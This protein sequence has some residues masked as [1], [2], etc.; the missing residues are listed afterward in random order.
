MRYEC[1]KAKSLLSKPIVADSWFH[2][3]RSLNAYRGCEHGCVYCDGMSEG[4]HVDD[5]FTCVRAK[6]NAPEVLRRELKKD[7][8]VAQSESGSETL[9]SF[10][11]QDDAA[12]LAKQG[13]RKQVIGVCGGVSDGYQPAEKQYE[14]TRKNLEVLRDFGMPV[15]V[16]TKSDLVLRDLDILK[17]IHKQAFANVTFTITMWDDET[18]SVLEPNSAS[19]SERFEALKEVRKAGLFGGVMAVPLIPGIGDTYENITSLA[20]E[21]KQS[22]A[23]SIVFGGLT[24][25]PGRQKEY[26]LNAVKKHFPDQYDLLTRIYSKN[27]KY[28]RPDHTQKPVSVMIRGHRVCE[29]VGISDRSVRHRMPG[30]FDSN[31]RV[32]GVLLD[33]VFYQ[34]YALGRPWNKSRRYHELATTLEQGVGELTRLR[35]EGVLEERLHVDAE[36]ASAVEDILDRGTC[37]DL[38]EIERMLSST[39]AGGSQVFTAW[40]K[41]N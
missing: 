33:I 21:A 28:G 2:V 15:F 29:E 24:L 32:L 38:E 14:V 17:E 8:F 11:D 13:P 5:F 19:T 26:F 16:L 37:Q 25:K 36:M 41:V 18:K 10:L 39:E 1:I 12:R 31:N 3:N 4:Y 7:G 35:K 40:E 9:L 23:E 6:E 27:D 22:G 34:V 30:E 20:K